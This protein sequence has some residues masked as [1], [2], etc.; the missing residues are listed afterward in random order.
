M[1]LDNMWIIYILSMLDLITDSVFLVVRVSPSDEPLFFVLLMCSIILGSWLFVLRTCTTFDP[2]NKHFTGVLVETLIES[3][4]MILVIY[5]SDLN[6]GKALDIVNM[7]FTLLSMVLCSALLFAKMMGYVCN[8][9]NGW[10][11]WLKTIVSR[12]IGG[13]FIYIFMVGLSASAIKRFEQDSEEA[14]RNFNIIATVFNMTVGVII[15]CY[16]HLKVWRNPDNWPLKFN[17]LRS[18]VEVGVV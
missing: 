14:F 12:F 6:E 16:F 9:P 2:K 5:N 7:A 4:P 1:N 17:F 15:L 8:C 11:G 13:V 3:S 18:S 10:L